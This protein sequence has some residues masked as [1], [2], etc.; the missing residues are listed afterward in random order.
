M[1]HDYKYM[2]CI[3]QAH[4]TCKDK[5][6]W[7]IKSSSFISGMCFLILLLLAC[8]SSLCLFR[9]LQNVGY[10]DGLSFPSQLLGLTDWHGFLPQDQEPLSWSRNWL[11][12][13][14]LSICRTTF[15]EYWYFCLH[16]LPLRGPWLFLE[17]KEQNNMCLWTYLNTSEKPKFLMCF[18]DMHFWFSLVDA[19]AG[20]SLCTQE[21]CKVMRTK[22]NL[23]R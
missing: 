17:C 10:K 12:M 15:P 9:I 2:A 11:L 1:S 7:S 16:H 18:T 19:I 6:K 22:C 3:L 8:L 20:Q 14:T 13:F 5:H 23:K 4:C 21:Y